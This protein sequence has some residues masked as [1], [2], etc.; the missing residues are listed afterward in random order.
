MS[1]I[2]VDVIIDLRSPIEFERDKDFYLS[3]GSEAVNIDF[4]KAP[5]EVEKLDR[6]KTYLVVCESGM[7]SEIISKVMISKGFK[8]V[9]HLGG[10]VRELKRVF[11][12]GGVLTDG[13]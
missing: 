11:K 7:T 3:I 6:N 13:S 2:N 8:N 9:K 5:Q 12:A 10:G 1:K 4:F